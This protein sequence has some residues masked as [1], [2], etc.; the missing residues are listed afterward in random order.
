MTEVLTVWTIYERPIDHPDHWV[1]RA[2]D[3]PGGSRETFEISDSL[4]GIRA[5][6]PPYLHRLRR[7]PNDD[8]AIYES[9]I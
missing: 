4:E 1:L 7:D 8:P 2:H 3:L 9:W 5:K 6:V